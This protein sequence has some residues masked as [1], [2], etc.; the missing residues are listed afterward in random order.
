V[1]INGGLVQRQERWVGRSTIEAKVVR[2][3]FTA[4]RA[5]RMKNLLE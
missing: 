1:R 4:G 2:K 3:I 5:D